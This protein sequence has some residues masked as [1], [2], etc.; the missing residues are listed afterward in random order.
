MS[1]A[2]VIP[3]RK[4]DRMRG[5]EPEHEARF[6]VLDEIRAGNADKD[7]DEEFEYITAM[8]E[9]VRQERYDREQG[10]HGGH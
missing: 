8:V 6:A 9:A 4:P 5:L 10:T 3:A 1:L 2:S 7:P